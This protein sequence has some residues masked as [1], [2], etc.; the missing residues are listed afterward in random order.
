MINVHSI[1][2][3]RSDSSGYESP[4][5]GTSQG[6]FFLNFIEL[7]V[8]AHFAAFKGWELWIYHDERVKDFPCWPYLDRLG[9]AGIAKLIPTGPAKTLCGSM[10]WRMLPMLDR[11]VDYFICRDVD[12]LPMHRDRVMVEEFI[13]S[14]AAVHAILDSES[15]CGPLMGGMVGF[16]APSLR[17]A[18]PTVAS[19]EDLLG[20]NRGL[21]YDVHG[22][23]Q[24]FLNSV[25]WPKLQRQTLIHQRRDDIQYPQAM[26]TRKAA[27]QVTPLDKVIRHIGAAYPREAAETIID[28]DYCY[29]L[30][31]GV[32]PLEMLKTL[33][34][35]QQE[36]PTD[37][38]KP[39][40]TKGAIEFLEKIVKPE[41]AVY[42]SGGGASSEWYSKRC[43]YVFTFET[44]PLWLTMI[45]TRA[46]KVSTLPGRMSVAEADLVAID[47]GNRSEEVRRS[48]DAMKSGAYLVLDNSEEY[49]E[50]GEILKGW[51]RH[52]FKDD[53]KPWTTSIWRK[54]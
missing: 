9:R 27:P 44:D 53:V 28:R 2:F 18:F 43:R 21:T 7:T 32:R 37:E 1:A 38:A 33:R 23:D 25:V 26:E 12:S 48:K 17:E 29:E 6:I 45:H 31:S 41:W 50:S 42:E 13:K 3:F 46:P 14:G 30:G 51:E 49:P 20:L 22:D 19:H 40:Y 47:G 15:H 54:P 24:R 16:H 34:W 35:P 4:R 11:K 39:W 8:K 36:K 52:D 10:L 5:A